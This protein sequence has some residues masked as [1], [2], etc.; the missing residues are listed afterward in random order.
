VRLGEP[1][2]AGHLECNGG[3][4]R[5]GWP[6]LPRAAR[7]RSASEESR[8]SEDS[9]TTMPRRGPD[10]QRRG[11]GVLP[12]EGRDTGSTGGNYP[13]H[14]PLGS[15][16]GPQPPDF[17]DSNPALDCFA[18]ARPEQSSPLHPPSRQKRGN[19][20]QTSGRTSQSGRLRPARRSG[21]P[22]RWVSNAGAGIVDRATVARRAGSVRE[23]RLI[24]WLL[25]EARP[26]ETR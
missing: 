9:L 22:G 15:S 14:L 19:A 12:C 21:L 5:D 17:I 7:G 1:T 4:R 26:A 11:A 24:G 20:L 13:P 10:G 16:T 8:A 2:P 3:R 6:L 23:R 18:G 25:S